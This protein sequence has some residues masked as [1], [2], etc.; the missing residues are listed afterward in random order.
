MGVT[1]GEEGIRTP[2]TVARMPHFECG[3]FNHS[4]TS[5]R[6]GC[7]WLRG[8]CH[9]HLPRLTQGDS[10]PCKTACRSVKKDPFVLDLNAAFPYPPP[11]HGVGRLAPSVFVG[12]RPGKTAPGKPAIWGTGQQFSPPRR[13]ANIRNRLNKKTAAR[14]TATSRTEHGKAKKCSQ[15]SKPAESNTPLPPTTC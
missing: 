11:I 15:S 12:P 14:L 2:D 1:G 8:R 5:P 3:A 13:L 10:C 7:A 6:R 4:A 9:T